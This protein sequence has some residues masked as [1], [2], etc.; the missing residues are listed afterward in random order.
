MVSATL[1]KSVSCSGWHRCVCVYVH[2]YIN[3]YIYK[4]V[5]FCN[6]EGTYSLWFAVIVNSFP[7]SSIR[8]VCKLHAFELYA[9][10]F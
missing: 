10:R 9:C 1:I 6:A 3:I 4:H 7:T 8:K 5:F 2:I